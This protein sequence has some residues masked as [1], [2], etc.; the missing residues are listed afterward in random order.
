M[1]LLWNLLQGFEV[2]L[3]PQNLLA[4]LIGAALGTAVGVLPGLGPLG[5]AAL[6]LPFTYSMEPTAAIIMI[7]GIYYGGM[8]GGSTTS[9]LLNVPGETASVVT[10]LDG[11]PLAQKGRA[12][13]T[14]FIMAIGSAIAAFISL[15]LLIFFSPWLARFGL[16]FGPAEFFAVMTCGLILL[17]R[18]SGGNLVS[19]LFPL[20]IGII[21]GTVGQEAVSS[22][23]RFTFGY[24]PLIAGLELT[25]IA[26]GLFGI[27]EILRTIEAKE[28]LPKIMR[29][30]VRD[31]LPSRDEWRRSWGPWGRGSL[32]G[33]V[34]GLLPGPSAALSSFT[35]YQLEK[36]V[37]K[38]R[39]EMGK[40][41]IEGVAGPEA[42]NNAA[43][44]SGM[45]PVLALGL[46]FSATLA[47]ILAALMIHGIQPGP[48]LPTKH[49]DIFW[50]VIASM[51]VGNIMLLVL[52]IPMIGVWVSML[53]VPSWLLGAF[54]LVIATLGTY[55]VRGNMMDVYV[56]AAASGFGY[57]FHKLGFSL[58][59]LI[60]GLILG[61]EIEKHM[62][63]GLFLSRGHLTYFIERPIAGAIW[64]VTI[65][66]LI[67][68]LVMRFVKKDM[69]RKM[70][71]FEIED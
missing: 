16:K 36:K 17:S 19:N 1:D 20:M 12:A 32:V 54:V 30:R 50:G 27:A 15:V 29:I 43:A 48:L 38:G 66:V 14:L 3:L 22:V 68:V 61:P 58:S 62:R 4:A 47:L 2:A 35:S 13:P 7:A 23:P 8:Y 5:G 59:P 9:V 70:A 45:I 69:S 46:P 39:A 33:F 10:T 60:L 6:I 44:T 67:I 34:F 18:V 31:M 40:G 51:F 41:A 65:T 21:A 42:A 56:L 25:A 37:A 49:P 53:R 52:N 55:S 57:F 64:G 24:F 63:Q 71:S 26:I 11:Y 28:S